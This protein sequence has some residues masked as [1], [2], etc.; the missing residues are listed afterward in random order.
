MCLALPW[1][2][3]G[4]T[5]SRETCYLNYQTLF[6]TTVSYHRNTN[7]TAESEIILEYLHY[8][9]LNNTETFWSQ[10]DS[11]IMYFNIQYCIACITSKIVHLFGRN[12]IFIHN[13]SCLELL[14]MESMSDW[15]TDWLTLLY[16]YNAC[17]DM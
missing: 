7:L 2:Y 6:Q 15:L 16:I 17:K 1:L 13:K 14:K 3:P 12:I 11:I 4:S 10:I 5:L 9:T 8:W